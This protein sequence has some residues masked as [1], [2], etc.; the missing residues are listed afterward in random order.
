MTYLEFFAVCEDIATDMG[1]GIII[2]TLDHVNEYSGDFPV[3]VV[4]PPPAKLLRADMNLVASPFEYMNSIVFMDQIDTDWSN[5]QKRSTVSTQQTAAI[6]F[7][8]RLT[9]RVDLNPEANATEVKDDPV[10]SP[11]FT[12]KWNALHTA[13]VILTFA[14]EIPT[15]FDCVPELIS[16]AFSSAYSTAFD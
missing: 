5:A 6:A 9:T 16:G 7:L 13:G 15:N 2:D 10:I 11:F 8:L 14:V 12:F 1:Y 4:T 3:M